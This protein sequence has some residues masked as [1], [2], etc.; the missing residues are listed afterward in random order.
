MRRIPDQPIEAIRPRIS[1]RRVNLVVEDARFLLE[2]A[3]GPADI[4]SARRH[5]EIR[6]HVGLHALGI[7]DHRSAGFHDVGDALERDPAAGIAAHGEAVQA[8]IEIVLDTRRVEHRDQASLEDVLGLVRQRR[9]LGGVIVAGEREHAAVARSPRGIGV[10]E[11]VA[12]TVDT[13]AFAIPHRE[14]AVVA[15]L[16]EEIQL[17]RPP[18]R[19]GGQVFVDARLEAHVMALE[20]L[21]RAPQALVE[22]AK[23]RAAIAR[24]ESG[25]VHSGARITLALQHHQPDQRLR[26]GEEH[27]PAL[28]RVLVVQ[29]SRSESCVIDG[30]VHLT[31]S[32]KI[33]FMWGAAG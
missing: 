10:L 1:E 20:V 11:D 14:H 25:G 15:R 29:G 13:R 30:G 24:Y 12:A 21:L 8:Q 16:G 22:A 31:C 19:G 23:R 33:V 9:G 2:D 3:V 6:R 7:D 4:E 27:A 32:T 26:A 17:L 18:D 28:E 5:R